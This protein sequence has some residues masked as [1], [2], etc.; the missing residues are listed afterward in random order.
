MMGVQANIDKEIKD[1]LIRCQVC[2][3]II[4]MFKFQHSNRINQ[5]IQICS[6]RIWL[7]VLPKE[8]PEFPPD[9]TRE[10]LTFSRSLQASGKSEA[11][12]NVSSHS[13]GLSKNFPLNY[14]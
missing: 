14:R 6:G 7:T 10:Q 13:V 5:M 11:K 2:T 4:Q 8:K 1:Q 9:Q 12:E 3:E